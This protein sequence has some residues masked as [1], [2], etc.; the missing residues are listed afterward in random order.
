MKFYEIKFITDPDVTAEVVD[1]R[2]RE[3]ATRVRG[4]AE[5]VG[6]TTHARPSEESPDREDSAV[7]LGV[8]D[9][10]HVYEFIGRCARVYGMLP[11]NVKHIGD[12]TLSLKGDEDAVGDMERDAL[13]D[14]GDFHIGEFTDEAD[15]E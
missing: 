3:S 12:E 13:G 5:V 7:F 10:N 11:T 14:E 9:E 8:R 6:V 15:D 1:E 2:A 4:S